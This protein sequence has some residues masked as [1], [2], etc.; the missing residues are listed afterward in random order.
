MPH[1]F[2]KIYTYLIWK[3]DS[4]HKAPADKSII[5]QPVRR[6]TSRIKLHYGSTYLSSLIGNVTSELKVFC[7]ACRCNSIRSVYASNCLRISIKKS[8]LLCCAV[9]L[10]PSFLISLYILFNILPPSSASYRATFLP[11]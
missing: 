9:L 4:R 7:A 2:Q 6:I 1:I 5:I 3:S 11:I 10:F 8:C